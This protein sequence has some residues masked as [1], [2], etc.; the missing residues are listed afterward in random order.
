[1]SDP[2]V[3]AARRQWIGL[4]VLALPAISVEL[5]P[6]SSQLLGIVDIYG[7]FV[8]GFLITM[9]TLGESRNEF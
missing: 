4:M 1:M 3:K 2:G 8:A 5:T 7:F 9:G 6:S